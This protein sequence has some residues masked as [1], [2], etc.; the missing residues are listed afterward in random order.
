MMLLVA[1]SKRNDDFC[2]ECGRPYFYGLVCKFGHHK[3]AVDEKMSKTV[4]DRI[5]ELSQS[6]YTINI[7]THPD[8]EAEAQEYL[9][10]LKNSSVQMVELLEKAEHVMGLMGSE[11]AIV[12]TNHGHCWYDTAVKLR[13]WR[14]QFSQFQE[15]V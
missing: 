5:K 2:I 3:Q 10:L 11:L 8:Y 1:K 12:N 14:E 7:L 13:E 6:N 4:T 9:S 15:R